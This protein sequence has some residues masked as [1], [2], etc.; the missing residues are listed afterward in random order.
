MKQTQFIMSQELGSEFASFSRPDTNPIKCGVEGHYPSLCEWH[1]NIRY[2]SKNSSEMVHNLNIF[3]KHSFTYWVDLVF[4]MLWG[5]G[6]R[7]ACLSSESWPCPQLC[8]VNMMI[9]S[10]ELWGWKASLCFLSSP[11][12]STLQSQDTLWDYSYSRRRNW[13]IREFIKKNRY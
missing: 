3:F 6:K 10:I 4:L 1:I 12:K 2:Y 8:R 5:M 11:N 7:G 13:A 9:F